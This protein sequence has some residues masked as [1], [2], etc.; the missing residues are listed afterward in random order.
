[1]SPWGLGGLGKG[2]GTA[3]RK[4]RD[5]RAK[6]AKKTDWICINFDSNEM[7]RY[8][9]KAGKLIKTGMFFASFA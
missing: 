5:K 6:A 9:G 7:N 3:G 4:K 1:V 2:E 8:L